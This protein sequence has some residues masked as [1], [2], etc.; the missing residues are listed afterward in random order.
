MDIEQSFNEYMGIIPEDSTV[1]KPL[2]DKPYTYHSKVYNDKVNSNAQ[3][4]QQEIHKLL[5][6]DNID[7][8]DE[9]AI[10]IKLLLNS[11]CG[12]KWGEFGPEF[13]E[14]DNPEKIIL[15]QITYDTL[16]RVFPDK[17]PIKPVLTDTVT[18]VV[19]GQ[20]TG[21]HFQLYRIWFNYFVEF[22]IFGTSSLE[23][24][25]IA[26]KFETILWTYAG[27]LKQSG[28]SEMLFMEEIHPTES[29]SFRED[30]PMRTLHYM[31]RIERINVVRASTLRKIEMAFNNAE[32]S[33]EEGMK[34]F[35][36]L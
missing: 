1:Q 2:K 21:D 12:E 30:I 33:A 32:T 4:P 13:K 36:S 20:E 26:K 25:K 8:I 34:F 29:T 10:K 31:F 27:F 17:R 5:A 23:A 3:I 16:T 18:E 6:N 24:R 19:N 35:L 9:L 14:S 15:P 28:I 11:I 22:N 7:D